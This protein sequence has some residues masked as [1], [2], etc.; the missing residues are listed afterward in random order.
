MNSTDENITPI[1]ILMDNHVP[2]LESPRSP[3]SAEK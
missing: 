3:T 2:S 1:Q